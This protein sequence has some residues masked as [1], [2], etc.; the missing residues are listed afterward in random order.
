MTY[1]AVGV[2]LVLIII[3]YMLPLIAAS[4]CVE[5]Y[6]GF[7]DGEF[8]N[9]GE[10]VGI[11]WLIYISAIFGCASLFMTETFEDA[12]LLHG[13]AKMG[14]ARKSLL[15]GTASLTRRLLRSSLGL[16]WQQSYPHFHSKSSSS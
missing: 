13:A 14:L 1:L 15:R 3:M 7:V 5:D 6:R 11:G 12:F 2:G 8:V 16:F 10:E 4:G 9:F